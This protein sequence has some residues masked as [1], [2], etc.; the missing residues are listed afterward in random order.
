MV[1]GWVTKD[2]RSLPSLVTALPCGRVQVLESRVDILVEAT[3]LTLPPPGR[4]IGSAINSQVLKLLSSTEPCKE[5]Y[6][7]GLTLR[8]QN[9]DAVVIVHLGWDLTLGYVHTSMLAAM[10]GNNPEGKNGRPKQVYPPDEIFRA[11]LQSYAKE[12]GGSGLS[13]EDQLSRLRAEFG[14]DIQKTT[15]FKHKSRLGIITTRKSGLKPDDEAQ[16]LITLKADDPAGL[17]GIAAVKQRLANQGTMVSRDRVREILHDHFDDEFA[18]RFVGFARNGIVRV[19][20]DALGPFHK[21]NLDGHEKLNA[22]A[23]QMGDLH[24]GIYAAKDSFASG[25]M[26]ILVMPN[27]RLEDAIGHFFLDMTVAYGYRIPLQLMTDKGSE[28][29]QMLR[30]HRALR[31]EAA[32][33]FDIQRWPTSIQVPSVRNTAIE[34]FWRWKRQGEGHSIK[35]TLLVGKDSGVFNPSDPLH[36]KVGR[37]I[38]PP[39]I[40]ERLDIFQEYWNT[41]RISPQAKKKLPSGKSPRQLLIVPTSG[42]PDAKDCSIR[43]NPESVQRF[44]DALGG[45]DGRK[46]AFDFID[47]EFRAL[48]DG[49]YVA[50]DL[51]PISLSNVWEIFVMVVAHLRALSVD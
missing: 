5:L 11:A 15:L 21:I 9:P 8:D 39:L 32:P 20:L 23:L 16:L 22:Q 47:D 38:W 29:G 48:A 46:E 6:R 4:N 37:W 43:V 10:S 12:N 44:R 26:Q 17:W 42:R 34:G 2:A 25:C 30:I 7:V 27:V 19:P 28:V 3:R 51:P 50:L 35:D 45:E 18:R 1:V 13:T 14:I 24:F 33:E 40:Q 49:A 31:L 41:H 36:V